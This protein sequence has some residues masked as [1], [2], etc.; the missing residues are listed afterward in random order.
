MVS[1]GRTGNLIQSGNQRMH[2]G[3]PYRIFGIFDHLEFL[4]QNNT[5][6]QTNGALLKYIYNKFIENEM[7]FLRHIRNDSLLHAARYSADII[8][9]LILCGKRNKLMTSE[10]QAKINK[11]KNSC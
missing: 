6:D 7:N 8:D 5:T 1:W 11:E 9:R 4:P 3:I 10:W 2:L